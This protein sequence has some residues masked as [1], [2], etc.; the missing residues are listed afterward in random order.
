M[1]LFCVINRLLDS[2]P[3]FFDSYHN[4]WT[5]LIPVSTETHSH[6][7]KSATISLPRDKTYFFLLSEVT[8]MSPGLDK[9]LKFCLFWFEQLLLEDEGM[10]PEIVNNFLKWKHCW[11]I[12]F[13]HN[14]L[15]KAFS[16]F[17][18]NQPLT[19]N[20]NPCW[21][22]PVLALVSPRSVHLASSQSCKRHLLKPNFEI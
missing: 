14:R 10:R 17:K 9:L 8:F 20:S 19:R 22:F 12:H 3:T 18:A 15:R 11:I 6:R 5:H 7:W 2:V 16:V 13:P 21:D 4:A 1:L